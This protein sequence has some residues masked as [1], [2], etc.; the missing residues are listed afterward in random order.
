[1]SG[2]K[3]IKNAKNI[4]ITG[5]GTSYNSALIAKQILNAVNALHEVGVI[6]RD[7]KP[8]NILISRSNGDLNHLK[9]DH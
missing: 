1:M 9:I 8:E 3:L 4:Y 5:S 6:H 7:I 2:Q